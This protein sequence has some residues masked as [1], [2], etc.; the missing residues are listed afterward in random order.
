[1]TEFDCP[2]VT[3]YDRLDVKIRLLTNWLTSQGISVNK[4]N[5]DIK[6]C[7]LL[8][9]R[10]LVMFAVDYVNLYVKLWASFLFVFYFDLV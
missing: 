8:I 4:W 5:V 3:L 2:Y 9:L 1:M 6:M 7:Q 10:G